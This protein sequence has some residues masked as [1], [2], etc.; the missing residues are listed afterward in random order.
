M[1]ILFYRY[2]SICEPDILAAFRIL[3]HEVI[4]ERTEITDKNIT[5]A[6][7]VKLVSDK[8]MNDK[9]DVVFSMNFYPALSE[10]CNIFKL[11]YICWIV[12][13]PVME[14]YSYSLAKPYNKVFIFDRQTYEELYNVNPQG[15]FY[16][17]LGTNVEK[18]NEIIKSIDEKD[19]AKYSH[20]ISF[21]GSLYREKCTYNNI[22]DRLPDYVRGY[23]DGI[24]EAQYLIYGYNMVEEVLD[25][26]MVNEFN[27]YATAY[28]FPE[29]SYHNHKAAIAQLVINSKVIE[30]E[31]YRLLGALSELYDVNVYTLSD[32]SDIPKVHNMGYAKSN[33]EMQKIFNLSKINLNMTSKAIRTGLSLRIWDVLGCG[34]FL[35]TNYQQEL[36]E[37]FQIG[38][39]LETYGSKQELLDKVQYYLS[40]DE[41]RKQIALNGYEK[42]SK[43]HSYVQRIEEMLEIV[44]RH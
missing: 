32:T 20:D 41:E 14:L 23:L 22:V 25:D 39:D 6:Q 30:L 34:G 12:D 33:G 5:F 10:V 38:Q 43:L 28:S 27:K 44:Q 15:I 7:C 19:K 26:N 36:M 18:N 3:G 17:P 35:I 1:K 13:C 16:F 37:Y 9:F 4:E 40:H 42:V 29:L 2:N 8:L 11:P 31:R 21:I 24:I